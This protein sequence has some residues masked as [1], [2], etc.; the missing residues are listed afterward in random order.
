MLLMKERFSDE[1][2]PE[3]QAKTWEFTWKRVE[4]NMQRL[5]EQ[6]TLDLFG[7]KGTWKLEKVLS[8]L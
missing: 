7:N 2:R 1:Q 5:T 8:V 4:K 6:A 3:A